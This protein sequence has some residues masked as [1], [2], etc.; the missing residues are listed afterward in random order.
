M[1]L[2]DSNFQDPGSWEHVCSRGDLILRLASSFGRKKEGRF[3]LVSFFLHLHSSRKRVS[4]E[5]DPFFQSRYF[6]L[7]ETGNSN[8]TDSNNKKAVIQQK[9]QR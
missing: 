4:D 9:A 6:L 2:L 3:F 1:Q 7:L 5:K 8:P